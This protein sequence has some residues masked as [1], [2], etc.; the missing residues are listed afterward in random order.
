MKCKD[1]S[2]KC[3][4]QAGRTF[5]TRYKEHI[6][7]ITTNGNT[8]KYAQH[9]FDTTHNYDDIDEAI[10]ILYIARKSRM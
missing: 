7:D 10:E 8:S 9:I 4:G 2:Q 5:C 1:C 6:R 3:I